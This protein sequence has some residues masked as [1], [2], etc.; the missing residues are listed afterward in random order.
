MR[1]GY[2]NLENLY[3]FLIKNPDVKQTYLGLK[4]D[5]KHRTDEELARIQKNN[6]AWAEKIR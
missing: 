1:G 3:F 5:I 4:S 2:R 6:M